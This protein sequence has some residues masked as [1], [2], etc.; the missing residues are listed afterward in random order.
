MVLSLADQT[1][2]QNGRHLLLPALALSEYVDPP[3]SLILPDDVHVWE[4]GEERA[5]IEAL[6]EIF[7]E[8]WL[9]VYSSMGRSFSDDKLAYIFGFSLANRDS[10]GQKTWEILEP[11]VKTYWEHFR[12]DTWDE[13]KAA[14]QYG[15]EAAHQLT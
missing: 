9:R 12:Q 2:I 14:I 11:E 13:F 7:E 8:H 4:S 3:A 10:D 1:S 15:H 5:G 6:L